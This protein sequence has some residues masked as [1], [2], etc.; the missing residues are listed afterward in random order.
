M[1]TISKRIKTITEDKAFIRKAVAIT[2]PVALQGLLN[3]TLN[4]ADFV[5]IGQLGESTIAAVGL[6]N[7]V[8]FVFSLLLF[9]VV[10]GSSILT[11][12]YWG[13]R[14]I[15]NI[16]KV[17]GMSLLIGVVAS[18][19]FLIPCLI[20]P[21][22]VMRIFTPDEGTIAIG[23]SYLIIVAISYPLTAITNAYVTLLRGVNEVKAPVIISVIA[24]LVNVV[25]NYILIFGNLG[26]PELG[27][28]GA[29]IAT[30][31]ARIVET[32]SLLFFVYWKKGPAAAPFKEMFTFNTVFTKKYF[33]TVSPVIANEF[34]WGLGVTIYALVY[35]RMGNAAMASITITQTVEQVL[36]V[37]FQGISAATAV[38][39]GNEMGA[40]ELKRAEKYSSNF[41]FLQFMFTL[42]IMVLCFV[43]RWPVIGLFS[44]SEQV[45]VSISRCFIVFIL[46]MP[47]KMFNFVNIV[48]ILRSGGDTKYALFLDCSGVWIIGIPLAYFG[49]ILLNLPIYYVYGLVMIEEIYKCFLGIRRYKQKKWLRN[50]VG[51]EINAL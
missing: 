35:G 13:K 42:L 39:L 44:V 28:A 9:G 40:N 22:F 12:Q 48:G 7:K 32:T 15:I 33:T 49:G 8:F 5:M 24:I 18:F 17:L 30:L 16:R 45:G 38:I 50:L 4:L 3:T 51:I 23:A 6:A 20:S 1:I 14:D 46:Y 34:M 41:I 47:F 25:L 27:V 37:V 21:T 29:A 2:I 36:M 26:A 10:S 19:I 11:A 31:I 43:I